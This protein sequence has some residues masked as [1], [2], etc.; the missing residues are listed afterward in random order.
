MSPQR[1]KTRADFQAERGSLGFVA[2]MKDSDPMAASKA[3]RLKP[4]W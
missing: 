1:R 2:S 3:S 4:S